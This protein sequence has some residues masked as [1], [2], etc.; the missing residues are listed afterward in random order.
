MVTGRVGFGDGFSGMV[1][2][3]LTLLGFEC[4]LEVDFVLDGDDNVVVCF[5]VHDVE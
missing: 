2:E 4:E 3:D 5:V 1:G